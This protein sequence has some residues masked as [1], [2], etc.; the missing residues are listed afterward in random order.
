MRSTGPG[1]GRRVWRLEVE[2]EVY[3]DYMMKKRFKK[4]KEKYRDWRRKMMSIG[5][6][7]ER[8]GVYRLEEEEEDYRNWKY[9]D[10][11]GGMQDLTLNGGGRKKI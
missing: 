8:R 1:E 7:G 6:G 5:H 9:I 4:E 11:E 2:E 3:R 10:S